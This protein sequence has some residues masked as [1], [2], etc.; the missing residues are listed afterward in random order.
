MQIQEAAQVDHLRRIVIKAT[1]GVLIGLLSIKG[2]ILPQE[3]GVMPVA[4]AKFSP[5]GKEKLPTP[6]LPVEEIFAQLRHPEDVKWFLRENVSYKKPKD[7]R[8]FFVKYRRP[9]AEFL[10]AKE[11]SCPDYSE[12]WAEWLHSRGDSPL[13]ARLIPKM[14]RTWELGKLLRLDDD[15]L[16]KLGEDI[17]NW[18]WDK[19]HELTMLR[20]GEEQWIFFDNSNFYA[21]NGFSDPIR[22][23]EETYQGYF[24]PEIGGLVA[25]RK[26]RGDDG[27]RRMTG[28]LYPNMVSP[29]MHEHLAMKERPDG[30]LVAAAD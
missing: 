17:G 14:D 9:A 25:Y 26:K 24:V 13:Y 27:L 21:V 28:S 23:L 15:A 5:P 6:D 8:D 12:F 2:M 11:G 4:S 19:S 22:A 10:H 18:P 20:T 7:V 3:S 16:K 1:A 30:V 29:V